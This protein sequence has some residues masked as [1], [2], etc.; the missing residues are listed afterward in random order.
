[1]PAISQQ[2]EWYLLCWV[3]RDFSRCGG[4]GGTATN[5]AKYD[6]GRR[7]EV[8]LRSMGFYPATVYFLC[9]GF[10]GRLSSL[11]FSCCKCAG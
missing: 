10:G 2:R 4:R 1:M 11:G 6:M 5:V 7:A 3:R 9:D 8:W